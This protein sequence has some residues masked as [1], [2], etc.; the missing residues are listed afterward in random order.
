MQK[1]VP[2]GWRND[3]R[4]LLDVLEKA[5]ICQSDQYNKHQHD[6]TVRVGNKGDATFKEHHITMN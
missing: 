3:K 4:M 5:K 2:R 1:P 6:M